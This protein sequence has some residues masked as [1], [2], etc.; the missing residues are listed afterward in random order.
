MEYRIEEKLPFEVAGIC[1][2]FCPENSYE[3]IP[4]FWG[5]VMARPEL[6]LMGTYGICVDEDCND[7]A[8]C[9]WIADDH[10]PG[11]AVPEGLETMTVPGGIWAV[12]PCNL[13][14]L[15]DTNTKM[16]QQWLPG[17]REYRLGGN[18]NLEVYGPFN[19]ENPEDCPVELWLPVK[20]A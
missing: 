11:S 14:T 8:F 19:G 16:W 9:Y 3:K 17:C 15:Q 18:Y 10:V 12:F 20:K 1:R 2:K 6:S 7:G 13:K 4:E 5:E